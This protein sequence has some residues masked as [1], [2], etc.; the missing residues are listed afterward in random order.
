MGCQRIS[1]IKVLMK[2]KPVGATR[3]TLKK[4]WRS[5]HL[6]IK[7]LRRLSMMSRKRKNL[8]RMKK[9]KSS[10]LNLR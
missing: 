9:K 3:L 4:V 1:L 6:I 2:V 10:H 7:S 8:S 5:R